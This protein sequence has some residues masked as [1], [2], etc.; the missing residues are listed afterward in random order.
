[1]FYYENTLEFSF[2]KCKKCLCDVIY[3]SWKERK[4]WIEQN[5]NQQ[6]RLRLN[7]PK[8]ITFSVSLVAVISA[9]LQPKFITCITHI[10]IN[11]STNGFKAM[12]D[13]V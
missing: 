10:Q 2:E 4:I 1:M 3:S 11:G 6:V 7:W 5:Q 9:V 13:L 8:K 12:P